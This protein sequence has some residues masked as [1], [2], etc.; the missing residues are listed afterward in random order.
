MTT[1]F[2]D[3]DT[4]VRPQPAISPANT[5]LAR[6]TGSPASTVTPTTSRSGTALSATD[7]RP[8]ALAPV[9]AVDK[10]IVNGQGDINQLAPFKYPWAWEFFLNANKNHW[11]PLEISMAQD[12]PTTTTIA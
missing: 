6:E 12:V 9:R 5:P 7:A 1:F 4:P 11:T 10:R 2:D 3:W 8:G